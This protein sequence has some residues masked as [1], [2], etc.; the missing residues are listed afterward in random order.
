MA[1]KK[2][3]TDGILDTQPYPDYTYAPLWFYCDW[4]N[5]VC[6]DVRL[7][8]D[9]KQREAFE[10]A[11][12]IFKEQVERIMTDGGREQLH[13]AINW[14]WDQVKEFHKEQLRKVTDAN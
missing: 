3:V 12:Q 4:V 1:N 8:N 11:K 9:P 10:K 2:K 5:A 6:R 14:Q 13:A 7:S